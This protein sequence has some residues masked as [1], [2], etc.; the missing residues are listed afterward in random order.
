MQTTIKNLITKAVTAIEEERADRQVPLSGNEF[1]EALFQKLFPEAPAVKKP[2]AKKEKA[3]EVKVE[4]AP[5]APVAEKTEAAPVTPAKKPRAKKAKKEGEVSETE[6]PAAPV[7]KPRAKKEKGPENLAKLTS[8]QGK[9]FTQI[10]EELKVEADKKKFIEHVNGMTPE[11][12]NAKKL[13]EHMREFLT[14]VPV[15]VEEDKEC[16]EVKFNDKTY[17][18]SPAD[19]KVYEEGSDGVHVFVGY[20]GMAAFVG[21]TIP[22]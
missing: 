8:A 20:A 22:Q 15:M 5:E 14:P 12:F 10:A 2:R 9:K 7:K 6:V 11:D 4:K 16:V 13:E 18:V 3:V 21:M 17:Y 1:L 19:N